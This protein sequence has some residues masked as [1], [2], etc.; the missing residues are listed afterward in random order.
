[1]AG[2]DGNAT[3]NTSQAVLVHSAPRILAVVLKIGRTVFGVIVGH[4]PTSGTTDDER[5]EWWAQL[6]A[7]ARKLPRGAIPMLLLDAN[8]RVT[9]SAPDCTFVEARIDNHNA[10]CMASLLRGRRLATSPLHLPTGKR[11]VTW[12]S[13]TGT[14]AQL[15]YV[16]LPEELAARARTV[17]EPAGFT[18]H[19]GIDHKVLAVQVD[20]QD[21]VRVRPQLPRFDVQ[22]MRT[23]QGRDR[24]RQIYSQVPDVPWALHPDSHLQIVNDY[25]FCALEQHFPVRAAKPRQIHVSEE[26]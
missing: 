8:A 16:V 13:P 12:V 6:D 10:Q 24:L 11:P 14:E 21:E 22:A 15:D 5:E 25:L 7:V 1:M 2:S 23:P 3:F 20:W 17:G 26:Q 9:A 18:D 19:N 4:A